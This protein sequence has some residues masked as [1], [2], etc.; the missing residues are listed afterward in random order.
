MRVAPVMSDWRER[1][2]DKQ[3][4]AR[5]INEWTEHELTDDL[6]SL[7]CEC[8]DPECGSVLTVTRRAY[9][10]V[11]AHSTRFIVAPNHENPESERI[12]EEH[13]RYAV[14]EAVTGED[15]KA[16]RRSYDR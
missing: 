6:G 5:R 13:E 1:D 12:V 11:R 2:A 3:V 10:A 4:R 7:R 14:I 15:A 8:R 16:A 9:H